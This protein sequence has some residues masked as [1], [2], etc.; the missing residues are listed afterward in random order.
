MSPKIVYLDQNIWIYFS[1]AYYKNKDVKIKRIC[2]KVIKASDSNSSIFP[3]SL[4]HLLESHHCQDPEK[5]DKLIDFMLMISK[6]YTIPTFTKVI[7]MEIKNATLKKLGYQT[8]NI[9]DFVIQKGFSN[10]Y[11]AKGTIQGDIPKGMK[12][13]MIEWINSPEAMI[14]LSKSHK[15]FEK[16]DSFNKGIERIEKE[17]ST[18]KEIKDEKRRYKFVL[19]K[20]MM[21][22]LSPSMAKICYEYGFYDSIFKG[23]DEEKMINFIKTEIPTFYVL[24]NLSYWNENYYRRI[25]RNDLYDIAHLSIAIPYCDIVVAERHFTSIAK[26]IKLDEKYKK[27]ILPWSSI[28]ELENYI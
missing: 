23:W 22:M 25:K 26:N 3:L 15:I 1:D 6:G 18:Y 24:F 17:R 9:K 19:A 8:S 7:E 27:V 10:M 4:N 21:A 13:L 11:G 28:D 12:N 20:N 14:P 2:E 16:D 5:R